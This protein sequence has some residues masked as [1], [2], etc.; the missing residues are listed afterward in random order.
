M[1]PL[2]RRDLF[3]S[4]P[5]AA[6][7]FLAGRAAGVDPPKPVEFPGMTVRMHQPQNLETPL[8]AIDSFLT[9][10][11]RHYVRSH[12]AVPKIDAKTWKLRVEGH[13]ETPQEFTLDE[14]KKLKPVTKPVTLE[15]AGR[16]ASFIA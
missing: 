3:R 13:V 10:T 12:F 2:S 7:P 6:V 9:P 15:C 5:L 1:P 11:D 16:S 8:S 14:L 4:A